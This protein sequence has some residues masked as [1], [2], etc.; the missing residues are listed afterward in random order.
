MKNKVIILSALCLLI[1]FSI[2]TALTI[3]ARSDFKPLWPDRNEYLPQTLTLYKNGHIVGYDGKNR[4]PS[5]VYEKVTIESLQ[6][7]E[8]RGDFFEDDEVPETIR[9]L[10]TDYKGSGYDRGHMAPAGNHTLT[11]EEMQESFALS[12]ICP[13]H[14]SCNRGIWRSLEEHVR[15]LATSYLALHV[16]T[17]TAYAPKEEPDGLRYVRYRVIGAS[18]IGVPSHLWKVIR[19]ER[20]SGEMETFV[21]LIPNDETVKGKSFEEFRS[22]VEKVERVS[23]LLLGR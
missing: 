17:G 5:W 18:D 3:E 21:Y 6:G 4:S 15:E 22:T 23:G 19:A 20:E 9:A 2:R 14:P 8:E 16:L 7:N 1:G 12:N 11:P 13:Q 10:L